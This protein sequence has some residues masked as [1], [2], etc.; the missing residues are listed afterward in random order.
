MFVLVTPVQVICVRA[1]GGGHFTEP[2]GQSQSQLV[3]TKTIQTPLRHQLRPPGLQD[4][5]SPSG[6]EQYRTRR[7]VKTGGTTCRKSRSTGVTQTSSGC[8]RQEQPDG[9]NKTFVDMELRLLLNSSVR[10][11]PWTSTINRDS[12]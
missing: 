6:H 3:E 9:M 4:T 8:R 12:D 1:E 2:T 5:I 10:W 11:L 7:Q